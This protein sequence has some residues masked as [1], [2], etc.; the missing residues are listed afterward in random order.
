L[1]NLIHRHS[2]RKTL[3]P[4]TR[5]LSAFL[6][7]IK[8]KKSYQRKKIGQILNVTIDQDITFKQFLSA[9]AIQSEFEMDPHWRPQANQLFDNLITYNFIGYFENFEQDFQKILNQISLTNVD[10]QQ[11]ITTDISQI[12]TRGR[13]TDANQKIAEFY[14]S[15]AQFMLLNTYKKDFLDFAYSLDISTEKKQEAFQ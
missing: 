10:N 9:I 15:E 13:K 2:K 7:K 8:G 6:S 1:D 11:L 12:N 3:R 4:Y 5:I 14:D